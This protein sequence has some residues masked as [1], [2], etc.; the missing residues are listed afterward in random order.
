MSKTNFLLP[1]DDLGKNAIVK[2]EVFLDFFRFVVQV[3]KDFSVFHKQTN[4]SYLVLLRQIMF[5]GYEALGLVII[6]GAALGFSTIHILGNL[7]MPFGQ[8]DLTYT[9]L[10]YGVIREASVILTAF[11]IAARSGTAITTELGIMQTHK[12]IEFLNSIGISPVSYLVIPRMIGVVV[13]SVVLSVYFNIFAVVGGW[14]LTSLFKNLSF[15]EFSR[16]FL[17]ELSIADIVLSIFKSFLF[18][19]IVSL[20]ACYHGFKVK[21]SYTEIPQRTIIAIVSILSTIIIVNILIDIVC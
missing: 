18:G 2:I 14:F 1:I 5:T 19:L 12:E 13:A 15:V 3:I 4:V 16:L 20:L 10:I 21:K 17:R 7:L 11:L 6:L 8:Q 9:V